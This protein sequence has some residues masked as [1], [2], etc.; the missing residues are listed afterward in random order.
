MVLALT[1]PDFGPVSIYLGR[2]LA[3]RSSLFLQ[4]TSTSL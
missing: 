3:L 1:D 2:G 4:R